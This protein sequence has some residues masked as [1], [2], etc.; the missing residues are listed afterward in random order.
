MLEIDII[1]PFRD[2]VDHLNNICSCL[3]RQTSNNFTVYFISDHSTDGSIE[4]LKSLDLKF[5]HTILESLS[6][7]PGAARNTGIEN[8]CGDYI[9]FIDA[10]DKISDDYIEKFSF[11]ATYEQ[12]DIIE[13]MFKAI[14]TDS[15]LVSKTNLASY[16]SCEDRFDSLISGAVPRLSWGKAYRREHLLRNNARFPDDI[17]NGEDHIFLLLAYNKTPRVSLIFDFMYFW[18]RHPNSL[19]NRTPTEKNIFDF[20]AVSEAKYKI[21]TER[22]NSQDIDDEAH[23]KNKITFSRRLFKEARSLKNDIIKNS[24][25]HSSLIEALK[26]KLLASE[27]LSEPMDIIKNDSTSYWSDVIH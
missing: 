20:I 8:S 15:D 18:V 11:V 3:N 21:F 17:Y 1:I 4:L 16:I 24:D 23:H 19:T 27:T 12:P 10:D 22:L 13:C 7:G 6:S 9:C 14:N 2:A 25:Q 5:K 26:M